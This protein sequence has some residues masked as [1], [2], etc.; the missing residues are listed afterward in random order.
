MFLLPLHNIQ[1][2]SRRRHCCPRPHPQANLGLFIQLPLVIVHLRRQGCLYPQDLVERA[3]GFFILPGQLTVFS[4]VRRQKCGA[5]WALGEPINMTAWPA[6]LGWG[7][8]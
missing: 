1:L 2:S 4:W 8:R 6:G 3:L 7:A 5:R